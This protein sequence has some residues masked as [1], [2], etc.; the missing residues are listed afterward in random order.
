M[1]PENEEISLELRKKIV[2][3]NLK[4][5]GYPAISKRFTVSR[6]AVHYIIAKHK[7]TNSVRIKPGCGQ[8][9]KISKTWWWEPNAAWLFC[10]FRRRDPCSGAWNH[11]DIL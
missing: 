2:D 8:K 4:G 7:E 10:C 11:E 3:A 5:E 1:L 6:T 9:C